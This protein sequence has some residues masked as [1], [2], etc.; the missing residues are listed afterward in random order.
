MTNQ[1]QYL[2]PRLASSLGII[3]AAAEVPIVFLDTETCGLG[4]LA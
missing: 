4:W 3:A 2:N 1:P